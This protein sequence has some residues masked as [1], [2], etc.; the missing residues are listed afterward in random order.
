[1]T[2]LNLN[3]D[4]D[5]GARVHDFDLAVKLYLSLKR[6]VHWIPYIYRNAFFTAA[7]TKD[8]EFF[9]KQI[10]KQVD[11]SNAGYVHVLDT[12]GDLAGIEDL[13][14]NHY[15]VT[16]A[17][18]AEEI[19]AASDVVKEMQVKCSES[20]LLAPPSRRFDVVVLRVSKDS[21]NRLVKVDPA[22]EAMI[23]MLREGADMKVPLVIMTDGSSRTWLPFLREVNWAVFMG[24]ENEE[25][26]E[27]LYS[28]LT[29]GIFNPRRIKL[30]V[31]ASFDRKYL[32]VLQPLKFEASKWGSL[33]TAQRKAEKQVYDDFLEEIRNAEDQD[34]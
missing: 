25:F 26:A 4:I 14:D 15:P 3:S 5:T 21:L 33:R 19:I 1:M 11:S 31:L 17:E 10:S 18:A 8:R 28:G 23:Y 29:P 9:A 34:V 27:R 24:D 20:G 13:Q 16:L 32:S 30:G 12:V 22:R 6:E 7:E 2:K